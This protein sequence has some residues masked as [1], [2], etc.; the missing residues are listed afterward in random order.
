MFWGLFSYDKKG[1]CHVQEKETPQ[2]KRERKA[3][4]DARNSLIK[5]ANKAKWIK[6]QKRWLREWTKAHRRAPSRIYKT[7]KHN[8]ETG[9][10]V[11][12]N[13]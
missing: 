13:S 1:P 12:K 10:F 9:A 6:E 4:L 11:V 5:K 7:W 2:E 3:D 8:K